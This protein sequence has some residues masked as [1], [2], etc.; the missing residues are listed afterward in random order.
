MQSN[1][2]VCACKTHQCP[3]FPLL[4]R[5][6]IASLIEILYSRAA[7]NFEWEKKNP[8]VNTE[9]EAEGN[10]NTHETS[11]KPVAEKLELNRATWGIS[12]PLPSSTVSGL[13]CNV[14]YSFSEFKF[15]ANI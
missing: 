9:R 2:F 7:D 8:F 11:K 6:Q 5:D 1:L 12:T 14:S 4:C 13:D 10:L 15:K 3:C